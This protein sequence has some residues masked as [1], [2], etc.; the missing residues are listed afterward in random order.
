PTPTRTTTL[1]VRNRNLLDH[2]FTMWGL[3]RA[4][5]GPT[6]SSRV[7]LGV[8]ATRGGL[9][10]ASLIVRRNQ[11]NPTRLDQVTT[12]PDSPVPARAP[13]EQVPVSRAA[14]TRG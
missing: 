14:P 7:P 12:T 13:A 9:R 1:A 8:K 5:L 4:C 3:R 2:V 6:H 10:H 11:V